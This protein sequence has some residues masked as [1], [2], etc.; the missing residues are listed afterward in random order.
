MVNRQ[1]RNRQTPTEPQTE[2]AQLL[3]RA[4]QLM[5]GPPTGNTSACCANVAQ[6]TGVSTYGHS[7]EVFPLSETKLD[8]TQSV[9]VLWTQEEQGGQTRDNH[10]GFIS[11]AAAYIQRACA[12][13]DTATS[14]SHSREGVRSGH[15][16]L[17]GI[18]QLLCR[19][20]PCYSQGGATK[21]RQCSE[22][23]CG[24]RQVGP[25]YCSNADQK[26]SI[27]GCTECEKEPRKSTRLGSQ[28]GN[29]SQGVSQPAR[30]IHLSTPVGLRR[31]TRSL[32]PGTKRI[33]RCARVDLDVEEATPVLDVNMASQSVLNL[34]Q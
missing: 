30:R 7:V 34:A 2:V 23:V 3:A 32:G 27:K 16:C 31:E 14:T 20:D 15:G 5:G 9:Q 24:G 8:L 4:S 25:R 17:W 28:T 22:P 6:A 18:R 21:T 26:G 33:G 13:K 29:S 11:Q 1:K 19:M 10:A 12:R